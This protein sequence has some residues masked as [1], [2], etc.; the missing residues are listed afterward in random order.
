MVCTESFG[1]DRTMK[2]PAPRRI[3]Q[4]ITLP[5]YIETI[6]C[7]AVRLRPVFLRTNPGPSIRKFGLFPAV[8]IAVPIAAKISMMLKVL[9]PFSQPARGERAVRYLLNDPP[10]S[11]FEVE[12][13]AIVEPL[14]PG[15]VSIFLSQERA[16]TLGRTAAARWLRQLEKPLAASQIKCYSEVAIGRRAEIVARAIRRR[17]IDLVLLPSNGPH[18]FNRLVAKWR[19]EALSRTTAHLVT[20]VP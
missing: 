6:T 2:A 19:G 1:I 9:I 15:K 18:W 4:T 13:L 8:V 10:S 17:D 7:C 12:L 11:S 16:A 14:T 20:I 5:D 3:G